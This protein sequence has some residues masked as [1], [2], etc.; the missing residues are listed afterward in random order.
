[1]EYVP[2][3]I[4]N[5]DF[6]EMLDTLGACL[7]S[8]GTIYYNKISGGVKCSNSELLK[9]DLAL[10]LLTKKGPYGALPCI[11]SGAAM[12]GVIYD[13]VTTP[14][15]T[16][17]YLQTFVDYFYR[18]CKTCITSNPTSAGVTPDT[19]NYLLLEDLTNLLL[20]DSQK[21]NLE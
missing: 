3:K 5:V 4:N 1:M 8:K 20:E 11:Y 2:V 16:T 7:A 12:P 17:T 6:D 18:E 21:I 19:G 14:R 15:Q 13:Q 9:L 10:Y